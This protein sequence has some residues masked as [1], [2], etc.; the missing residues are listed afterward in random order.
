MN[1]A[2]IRAAYPQYNDLSDQQ[3]ADGLY[4]K[5]YSD[6]DKNDFYNRIGFKQEP[7][8]PPAAPTPV[9]PQVL[10]DSDTSS[11]FMRG[12]TNYLPQ[13]RETL[14]GAGVL[15]GRVLQNLGAEATGQSMIESGL[16]RMRAA[17]PDMRVRESDEFTAALEKGVFTLLTDW[18]PYQ[19]GQ[20]VGNL[21]ELAVTMLAGAGVGAAAGAGIGAAPGALASAI[22]RN[23]VKKEIKEK[24]LEIAATEG[25]E[26][27]AQRFIVDAAKKEIRDLAI[28]SG[29]AGM[30]GVRGAG[31][32][33]GR[34]VQ[35]GERRGEAVEDI[36]LDRVLPAAAVHA[37]AEFVGDRILLGALSPQKLTAEQIAK[38]A[39]DPKAKIGF[40]TGLVTEVLKSIGVAGI[41][42][43]PVEVIQSAAERYGAQLS[44]EDA[45]ALKEYINATAAAFG[46]AVPAG[47]VGGVRTR[48]DRDAEILA[49]RSALQQQQQQQQQPPP[50][51]AGEVPPATEAGVPPGTVQL[52]SEELAAQQAAATA[53]GAANVTPPSGTTD[54]D[55]ANRKLQEAADAQAQGEAGYSTAVINDP[56]YG[57]IDPAYR[58]EVDRLLAN[59]IDAKGKHKKNIEAKIERFLNGQPNAR[60]LASLNKNAP[61]PGDATAPSTTPPTT[62]LAETKSKTREGYWRPNPDEPNNPNSWQDTFGQI[63]FDANYTLPKGGVITDLVDAPQSNSIRLVF[64]NSQGEEKIIALRTEKGKIPYW[65]GADLTEDQIRTGLGDTLYNVVG[66]DKL[67]TETDRNSLVQKLRNFLTGAPSVTE[68]AEAVETKEE[69]QAKTTKRGKENQGVASVKDLVSIPSIGRIVKD[70]T[71]DRLK[72]DI[73][74]NGITEPIVV[75]LDSDGLIRGVVSGA[76]TLLAAQELGLTQVPI[77][78]PGTEARMLSKP[79]EL[80]GPLR[81][82]EKPPYQLKVSIPNVTRVFKRALAKTR[83]ATAKQETKRA[84]VS[85]KSAI[86]EKAATAAQE[87]ANRKV[88]EAVANG[89]ITKATD[90]K[91]ETIYNQAFTTTF[92]NVVR[93]ETA[94]VRTAAFRSAYRQTRKTAGQREI[95]TAEQIA[96]RNK[97]TQEAQA[98]RAEEEKARLEPIYKQ[99]LEEHERLRQE[100][101]ANK[102]AIE[103]QLADTP[104]KVSEIDKLEKLNNQLLNMATDY[105]VSKKPINEQTLRAAAAKLDISFPKADENGKQVHKVSPIV[106]L[107]IIR[108]VAQSALKWHQLTLEFIP[109]KTLPD[110]YRGLWESSKPDI[111]LADTITNSIYEEISAIVFF[112]LKIQINKETGEAYSDIS[113]ITPENLNITRIRAKF[114]EKTPED[115]V[116]NKKVLEV[117]APTVTTFPFPYRRTR[118]ETLQ[119]PVTAPVE[120]KTTKTI[121]LKTVEGRQYK[122]ADKKDDK[123]VFMTSEHLQFLRSVLATLSQ[124]GKVKVIANLQKYAE[125]ER[126]LNQLYL[127]R[128]ENIEERQQAAKDNRLKYGRDVVN[129]AYKAV[130]ADAKLVRSI[131]STPA[132]VI[133]ESN[134]EAFGPNIPQ[135]TS[136]LSDGQRQDIID[137]LRADG[138]TVRELQANGLTIPDFGNHSYGSTTITELSD[139]AVTALEQNRLVDALN[140]I[141]KTSVSAFDVLLSGRLSSLLGGTR[142]VIQ[143]NLRDSKGK[144]VAG[145]AAS[146]GSVIYLDSELGLNEETLL[147]ESVHAA[148]ERLLTAPVSA[149]TPAQRDARAELLAIHNR[150]KDLGLVKK[151]S[152]AYN[153]LSEFV[154]EG[155]TDRKLRAQ[156]STVPWKGKSL[157]QNIKRVLLKFLGFD[158]PKSLL[159]AMA[160]ASDALF[161][162]TKASAS[163]KPQSLLYAQ[164]PTGAINKIVQATKIE[165]VTLNNL[166]S[167]AAKGY[168]LTS[169]ELPHSTNWFR[170]YIFSFPGMRFIA[171]KVQNSRQAVKQWENWNAMGGAIE[172]MGDK[173]NNIYTQIVLSTGKSKTYYNYYIKEK[174]EELDANIAK[175]S[176]SL[177]YDT[178]TTLKFMH[179]LTEGLHEPERRMIKYI[180]TVPLSISKTLKKV[181]GT[182]ISPADRRKEITD[183]LRAGALTESQAKALRKELDSIV[184][185]DTTKN[186]STGLIADTSKANLNMVNV[187]PFGSTPRDAVY[188]KDGNPRQRTPENE[189]SIEFSDKDA[190]SVTAMSNENANAVRQEYENHPNKA[191][192][193]VVLGNIRDIQKQTTEL[194]K[195]GNHWS[196]PVSNYINFYGWKNYVPLK[197]LQ[198]KKLA[199]TAH[200]RIDE[201]L[202]LDTVKGK[203]LQDADY[204][205]DG[206]TTVSNNP[207][208][209]T[210]SDAVRSAMRA[211]R[212][213]VTLAVKNSLAKNDKLNPNGTGLIDGKVIKHIPFKDINNEDIRRYKT[214]TTIFHHNKDGSIDVLQIRDRVLLDSIRR[215][216]NYTNPLVDIANRITSLVG[217]FHTRYN[218]QFAPMN[219]VRDALTNAWV[220]GAEQG[221]LQSIKVLSNIAGRVVGGNGLYRAMRVAVLYGNSDARSKAALEELKR[222]DSYSKDMI[223][224]I[225]YGGMVSYIQGI[226]LKSNFQ[227]LHR[228]LGRSGVM[229]SK[230]QLEK[231]L[232]IWNDMFELASRSAT[233]ATY[234]KYLMDKKG[235]KSETSMTEEQRTAINQ[236]AAAYVKNLANFEQVGEMGK[237]LG[238]MYMFIRPA[239]TGAVRAIE[240]V[241]P[242]FVR[243]IDK[244]IMGMPNSGIFSYETQEDGTR[245]YT[246]PQAIEEF[247][248]TFK[249]QQR[250]ARV[251]LSSLVSLGYLSYVMAAMMSDDDELGRNAVATDNMQQWTRYARF[252]IPKSI[253][254]MMGIK[255]P[256]IFQM[257]WGFGP[258]AFAAAGAQMAAVV[259]GA[260]NFSLSDALANIFLQIALDSFMPIPISR[261]PPTEMPL[262]FMLD[263]I[264]PS[265]ARP[266]LEFAL[267]KN[268]LGQD[269]YNDRSRRMGDAYTAGDKI[270]EMYKD[271]AQWIA[272]STL[273]KWDPSPNS[274]YFLANSYIDGPSRVVEG[275]TGIHAVGTGR[276]GFNPKTDLPLLGSFFGA[277]SNVD[278]R[279][280][281]VVERKVQEL[282]RQ[283]NMFKSLKMSPEKAMRFEMANPMAETVIDYY[284]KEVGANLNRLRKEANEVRRMTELDQAT[285][286]DW[287]KM[288]VLE[289]N[290]VKRRMIDTF[291]MYGIEVK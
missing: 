19:I 185:K 199:A 227:E 117:Q 135:E 212:V 186:P 190:Y 96:Q 245:K 179:V 36:P 71:Y 116:E 234:K 140:N 88:A 164:A 61:P 291:R 283:Y 134:F 189:R 287:L 269:I 41:K 267:N 252:H 143:D 38:I 233:F 154:A 178:E 183:Q 278:S 214:D 29:V 172:T 259:H 82:S 28:A 188:D 150:A 5:Y 240:A 220:M 182:L 4:N 12:I 51:P 60:D 27:A 99:R 2:E 155:L 113:T 201:M 209:Q 106:R 282:E 67:E 281:T 93:Q 137:E 274:L 203:D 171:Q 251:M 158:A 271:I 191:E 197:G 277:R 213:D 34:A 126:K 288:I 69:G 249:K 1:I 270:P 79:Y 13:L 205:L 48:F 22:T 151:G 263:S 18:L 248:K 26:A 168:G 78:I 169:A 62:P 35:E 159:D 147:H 123:N 87:V 46:M 231:F 256:V 121:T 262:E 45:E 229:R 211:G 241:T 146:D 15:A 222:T 243:N 77:T 119:G 253:T 255:E 217:Q 47:T 112:D 85:A 97:Q 21:G 273:G 239:A 272:D 208:L 42:E 68:A 39:A 133:E 218:Y 174:A 206:R 84:E 257:P 138:Y 105:F 20:G 260:A 184:F 166:D 165:N 31:E 153:S 139:T 16:A 58:A 63:H 73:A 224:Y 276:K 132:G 167:D 254:E 285:R 170:K 131:L 242:A 101:A 160:A 289:Q 24:A 56:R 261:M 64:T 114:D 176:K 25:G 136:E 81:P 70:D 127:K 193:D 40:S 86:E 244:Y 268:G 7:P 128:I 290:L 120:G 124:E 219:F 98:A 280:F 142:V 237:G 180:F 122:L 195:I 74:E 187:D 50:P 163:I 52:T 9:G 145:A 279:E 181:D 223:D 226:S 102:D 14:G 284:N 198:K 59:R 215:T 247:K 55:E 265:V 149:L 228:E 92:R 89:E 109:Y 100:R 157:W 65:Y 156:L 175:L 49:A 66:A 37:I 148:I 196:E 200:E 210:M 10:A 194:N 236:E 104:E 129:R 235:I 95:V 202:N 11:D 33:M 232:D 17:Q 53:A 173:I 32:V 177:G 44:L 80:V 207:I 115:K 111:K 43:A 30:A 8:P 108:S 110:S 75:E 161:M 250:N 258:G 141:N 230:E 91:A 94:K 23:L 204:A 225:E 3:L 76:D 238:A 216:Y 54:I 125:I 275:I 57:Q 192:I 152:P 103:A 162:P 144:R 264:A 221:P 90:K 130:E 286:S 107:S 266:L 72:A 83:A 118:A 246:N 6:L